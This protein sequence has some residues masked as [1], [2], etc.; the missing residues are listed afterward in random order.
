MPDVWSPHPPSYVTAILIFSYIS[1][2]I[3][4]VN[5]LDVFQPKLT[6]C[7]FSFSHTCDI[8][9]IFCFDHPSNMR[10]ERWLQINPELYFLGVKDTASW[11][12][13]EI[14]PIALFRT[15]A[16]ACHNSLLFCCEPG[17]L[18]VTTPYC[19]IVN[20]GCCSISSAKNNKVCCETGRKFNSGNTQTTV[21]LVKWLWLLSQLPSLKYKHIHI[22][23]TKCSATSTH[24]P[25]HNLYNT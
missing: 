1:L 14:V 16:S 6:V 11:I 7:V 18:P 3:Q 24:N 10:L 9:C 12:I 22:T 20:P 2:I 13:S 8:S 15:Q 17:L 25:Q 21:I 19:S 5:F 4:S 23:I